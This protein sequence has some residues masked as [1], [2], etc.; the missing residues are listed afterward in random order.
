[1]NTETEENKEI[2]QSIYPFCRQ[3]FYSDII[4]NDDQQDAII[5]GYLFIP[6]QLYMFRV[7]FSPIIRSTWLYLQH[8]RLST[9]IA[10]GW[11]HGWEGIEP[12]AIL[13]GNIRCCK[14]S[15]V[16]LM[17]GEDIIRNM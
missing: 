17:M 15:Q 7:M 6:N 2:L 3:R 14:Y 8:L 5:L 12:A 1:L 10:A 4:L 11:Y 9:G 13:V 16:L